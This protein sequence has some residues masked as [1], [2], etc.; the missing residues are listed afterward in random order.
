MKTRREENTN[1]QKKK[2]PK[3]YKRGRTKKK[4]ENS[5][6]SKNRKS[7][8]WKKL[9][10]PKKRHEKGKKNPGAPYKGGSGL[11]GGKKEVE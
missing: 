7:K 5:L 2:S 1:F 6:D 4:K 9:A 11:S 10:H 8:L 3:N